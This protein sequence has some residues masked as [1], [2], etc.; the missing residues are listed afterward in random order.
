[1]SKESKIL[2][3][4]LIIVVIV[5]AGFFIWR[6][7]DGKLNSNNT[8]SEKINDNMLEL[9]VKKAL[10][11]I[12]N[13]EYYKDVSDKTNTT[14]AEGHKILKAEIKDNQIYAYVVAEY[15]VYKLENNET[16]TVSATATPIVLIFNME[17]EHGYELAKYLVPKDGDDE[18]WMTSLK[19]IFL[20]DLIKEATSVNY[21]DEFYRKQIESYV[22]TL[23]SSDTTNTQDTSNDTV[24]TKQLL[25]DV[26]NSKEK[27]ISE[28]NKEVFL[29][30]FKIVENE[31][32][33]VDK[34]TFVD[35][36]E[37]GIEELVIYTT[38]DYGAYVIL[39]YEGG[40]VYGYMIGVRSLEN[41]KTDGSFMGSSGANSNEYSRMTFN[42]NSYTINTEAVYDTT[43]QIYKINGTNVSEEK[44]KEY[45]ETWNKKQNV[46]WS[47]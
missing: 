28:D 31:T 36:D 25:L 2:L 40:K 10:I 38:S 26:M 37:D 46:N 23:R 32:A 13:E 7:V 41:L 45:A 17:T 16:N 21:K 35:M 22:E 34:Y 39:H 18:V 29:K 43:N 5:G 1:M 9:S 14:P 4:L 12:A 15:G 24:N 33:K 3:F 6:N 11:E 47:K 19:E 42:K 20:E 30:D 44:A 27:F 8:A